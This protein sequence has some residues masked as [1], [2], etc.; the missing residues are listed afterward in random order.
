MSLYEK[1]VAKVKWLVS[2]H[3]VGG[4][5]EQDA[6]MD[7]DSVSFFETDAEMFVKKKAPIEGS[8]KIRRKFDWMFNRI[9]FETAREA[10]EG[11]LSKMVAGAQ[12]GSR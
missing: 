5:A 6:L 10:G 3:E 2:K 9:R 12:K 1:T 8:E 7:A 11:K 4:D